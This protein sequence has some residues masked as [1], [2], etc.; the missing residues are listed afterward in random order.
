MGH[1]MDRAVVQYMY[2]IEKVSVPFSS[3]FEGLLVQI[4]HESWTLAKAKPFT[5]T[6]CFS[7]LSLQATPELLD[8]LLW[9]KFSGKQLP[10]LRLHPGPPNFRLDQKIGHS[11]LTV[12]VDT[13]AKDLASL[14]DFVLADDVAFVPVIT[15]LWPIYTSF[16]MHRF[17]AAYIRVITDLTSG[18]PCVSEVAFLSAA[19]GQRPRNYLSCC[20]CCSL[21]GSFPYLNE[22]S[23]NMKYFEKLEMNLRSPVPRSVTLPT[24]LPGSVYIY[25]KKSNLAANLGRIIVKILVQIP[26]SWLYLILPQLF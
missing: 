13:L 24:E 23:L 15:S 3:L 17:V 9:L 12:T 2:S 18:R 1:Q 20:S 22:T 5:A 4:H 21:F 6:L 11:L 25:Y 8:H 14:R 7:N 16:Q 10:I 26:A 19:T